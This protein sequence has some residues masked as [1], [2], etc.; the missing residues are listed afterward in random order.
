V[1]L[2]SRSFGRLE[3][4]RVDVEDELASAWAV[5]DGRVPYAEFY[6]TAHAEAL[7]AAGL[8]E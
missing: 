7:K 5:Q 6:A 8:E 2:L 4:N 3:R 1:L